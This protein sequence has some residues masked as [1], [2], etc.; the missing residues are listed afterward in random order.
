MLRVV[1]TCLPIL[2]VVLIGM[3]CR[4]Y[5]VL[6]DSGCWDWGFTASTADGIT[7]YP[8]AT[9]EY[10]FMPPPYAHGAGLKL[11]HCLA[12]TAPLLVDAASTAAEPD[13]MPG[14]EYKTIQDA[15]DAIPASAYGIVRGAAGTYATGGRKMT[16]KAAWY[17]R[18]GTCASS[19]PV[20]TGRSSSAKPIRPRRLRNGPG[21]ART[22]R[23]AWRR[24]RR[25]RFPA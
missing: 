9:G 11:N 14:N 8:E 25:A 13:G 22:P 21:A 12:K 4:K 7:R 10:A 16:S 17:C 18:V 5:R 6:S 1:N 2:L 20:R 15:V 3:I 24:I 19:V 23:D